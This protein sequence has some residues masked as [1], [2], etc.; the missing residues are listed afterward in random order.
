MAGLRVGRS[1][2]KNACNSERIF[3][4]I[5]GADVNDHPEHKHYKH[6]INFGEMTECE[7]RRLA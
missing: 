5:N 1:A 2:S 4:Y 6:I 3:P 7:A